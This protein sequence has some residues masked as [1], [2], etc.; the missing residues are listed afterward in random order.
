MI[1]PKQVGYLTHHSQSK[2]SFSIKQLINVKE[3]AQ[4]FVTCDC[5]KQP[6]SLIQTLS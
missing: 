6:S 1:Y 5:L 3:I 2:T 4:L